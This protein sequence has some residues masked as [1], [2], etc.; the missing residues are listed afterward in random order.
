M[1]PRIVFLDRGSLAPD[2]RV[3]SP[4]FDHAWCEFEES[5]ASQVAE[6]AHGARIVI[7]NKVPITAAALARLPDLRMIAVAA[8]GVDLIDMEASRRRG[9]VVS[10]IRGY[11]VHAVPEHTFALILALRR[12]LFGYRDAVRQGRWQE[13]EQFGFCDH[14]IVDLQGARLGIIGGGAIGGRVADLARA[15]GMEPLFAGRKDGR[16]DRMDRAT[17]GTARPHAPWSEVLARSDVITLHCPL[18]PETRNMIAMPELRAMARR[19]LLV[20]TARGG[21]IDE[22]ALIAALE[23]GLIAGAGLD[24]SRVEPPRTDSP[25]VRALDRPNVILTPH[26]AWAS[27]AAMQ[28]LA[29]QLIDNIEAFAAGRP[30]NV[31]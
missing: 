28:T 29:D 20:N 8:T 30:V 6:R 18:T 1:T 11:A 26:I 2:V 10:N 19:P 27:R 7:T 12:N 23:E 24:V 5:T 13:A 21:L 14:P 31:V 25:L 15:F 17:H 4:A 9:I 3:R 16:K 22:A